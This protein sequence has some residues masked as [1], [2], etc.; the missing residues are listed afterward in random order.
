MGTW[1]HPWRKAGERRILTIP[2]VGGLV[3][4]SFRE[5]RAEPH[6]GKPDGGFESALP[7]LSWEKK[8]GQQRY[9]PAGEAC[10]QFASPNRMADALFVVGGIHE[11]KSVYQT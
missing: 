9:V 1:R 7:V 5:R 3:A 10:E 11:R 8:W 6:H 4:R 2:A